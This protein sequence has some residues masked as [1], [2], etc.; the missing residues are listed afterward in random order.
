M[1]IF[2]NP[3]NDNDNLWKTKAAFCQEAGDYIY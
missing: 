2:L 1:L 3:P